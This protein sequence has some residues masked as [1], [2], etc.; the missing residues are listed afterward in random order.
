MANRIRVAFRDFLMSSDRIV[1]SRFRSAS[2]V[3][4]RSP[5]GTPGAHTLRVLMKCQSILHKSL[6]IIILVAFL[7]VLYRITTPDA[8]AETNISL[9]ATVAL[10]GVVSLLLLMNIILS[11]AIIRQIKGDG[12]LEVFESAD[13]TTRREMCDE[14]ERLY[15]SSRMRLAKYDRIGFLA[16]PWFLFVLPNSTEILDALEDTI[17]AWKLSMDPAFRRH[18]QECIDELGID[19]TVVIEEE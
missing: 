11:R 16:E 6:P 7:V 5:F 15:Y 3:E 12:L 14:L 8:H 2:P 1:A 18:L 13:D 19:E 9:S 4:R 17:E 10:V